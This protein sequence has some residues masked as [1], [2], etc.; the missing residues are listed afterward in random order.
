M[1]S[2]VLKTTKS[3]KRAVDL[4]VATIMYATNTPFKWVKNVQVIKLFNM[5]RRYLKGNMVFHF[6]GLKMIS[7]VSLYALPDAEL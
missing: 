4:Q 3:E 2:Y 1:S 5:L 7:Y 6:L